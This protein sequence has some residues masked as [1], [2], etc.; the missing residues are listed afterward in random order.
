MCYNQIVV[1]NTNRPLGKNGPVPENNYSLIF[2]ATSD[3]M[4][5]ATVESDSVF[6]VALINRAYVDALRQIDSTLDTES[7][8]GL[9][10]EQY[11]TAVAVPGRTF[12]EVLSHYREAAATGHPV[13]TEEA[14]EVFGNV[15]YLSSTYTPILDE[16]GVCTHLLY[17]GRD[18]TSRKRVEEELRRFAREREVL[19]RE[20]FHRT[21]NNMSIIS[22]LF[23]IY[24]SDASPEETPAIVTD[25]GEK[26][27]AMSS[28]LGRL[29]QSSELD[30]LVLAEIVQDASDIVREEGSPTPRR[31]RV[32]ADRSIWVS[33]ELAVPLSMVI[34]QILSATT[35]LRVTEE[36]TGDI[37]VSVSRGAK[38]IR[39]EVA[40]DSSAAGCTN[41][42]RDRTGLSL[43]R[44]IVTH[45]LHGELLGPDQSK[46]PPARWIL[47]LP[48]DSFDHPSQP[49]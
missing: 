12:A 37:Q 21:K 24:A 20:V 44:E 1:E 14:V 35:R 11:A 33:L 42:L 25:I 6:R 9:T 17:V 26:I 29:Y 16:S 41:D 30:H 8:Q 40:S 15:F 13:T 47:R 39:I 22:S 7:L 23:S 10:I 31:T 46:P 3:Y 34:Q 48:E 19:I 38:E 43:I 5:L 36:Q 28:V 49:V 18:I 45:Q 2:N 4:L 32:D 27:Q